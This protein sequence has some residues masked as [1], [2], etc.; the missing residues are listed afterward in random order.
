MNHGH[1]KYITVVAISVLLFE[2]MAFPHSAAAFPADLQ[3][4]DE[5]ALI[6][7]SQ[8]KNPASLSW[9]EYTARQGFETSIEGVLPQPLP[10]IES[11]VLSAQHA[12]VITAYSS[13]VDQTDGDPWTTASGTRVKDG[14]IAANFLPFGTRVRIPGLFGD[15]VFY[16]TDRM[17]PR[18]SDRVDVWMTTREEA[19]QFGAK[20]AT[21]EV[22]N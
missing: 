1:H 19:L 11:L 17:H 21:I 3:K 9:E 4:S 15:K 6:E 22:Y 5:D 13:T 18:F 12:V 14:I 7:A 8:I 2:L 20:V 10:Q 16:V